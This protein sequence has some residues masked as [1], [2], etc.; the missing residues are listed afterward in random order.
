MTK[1]KPK[2]KAKAAA[3]INVKPQPMI[4]VEEL[5]P[6][7]ETRFDE[8]RRDILC[9][10]REISRAPGSMLSPEVMSR[11]LGVSYRTIYRWLTPSPFF[12]PKLKD[13]EIIS[14]FLTRVQNLRSEWRPL[15]EK[16]ESLGFKAVEK[17]IRLTLFNPKL[18]SILE[19]GDLT[20]DEKI[21]E[22]VM[23]SLRSLA[24]M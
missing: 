17:D 11:F 19:A 18:L 2:K 15:A 24:G 1:P 12:L 23:R 3:K 5:Q 9:Q 6:P 21:E 20:P 13:C 10:L 16:W 8:L 7:V 4:K 14:S 22:L